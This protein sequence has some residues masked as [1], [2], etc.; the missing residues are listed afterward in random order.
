MEDVRHAFEVIKIAIRGESRRGF[1][2]EAGLGP[3]GLNKPNFSLKT[4][5]EFDS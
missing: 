1:R 5:A 4:I 2:C 3:V